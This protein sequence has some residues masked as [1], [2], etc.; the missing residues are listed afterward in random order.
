MRSAVSPT[1]IR[2]LYM[3]FR[4][5]DRGRKGVVT[6]DDLN[7]IPELS[8]NPLGPRIVEL[9]D[10]EHSG[11]I[12]FRTF[13]ERMSVFS[14][15]SGREPKLAFL[16]RV[17]DVDGDG[18]VS[19][20]DMEATLKSMAGSKLPPAA[21]GEVVRRTLAAADMDGDGKLTRHEFEVAMGGSTI[22]STLAIPM[23]VAEDG[24]P[25]PAPAPAPAAA[26]AAGGGAAA[27]AVPKAK[28]APRVGPLDLPALSPASGTA[29][30]PQVL[31]A[32][33]SGE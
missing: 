31:S 26:A 13:L 15:H 29:D 4:K 21:I 27:A 14:G 1:E 25:A 24:A 32:A 10:E 7:M 2:H 11:H 23:R 3:R 8:T 5:L 6:V 9:F 33:H 12:N 22:G 18:Y 17:W 20:G 28:V 30:V 16:F 19:Q